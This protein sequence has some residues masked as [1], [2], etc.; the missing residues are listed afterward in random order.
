MLFIIKLMALFFIFIAPAYAQWNCKDKVKVKYIYQRKELIKHLNICRWTDNPAK[1][2]NKKC[3][4]KRGRCM[5]RVR[6][7]SKNVVQKR[8]AFGNLY[9]QKCALMTGTPVLMEYHWDKKW[10]RSSLCQF[11][12][13]DILS[14]VALP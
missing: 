7:L 12:N 11:E 2:M 13:G 3:Y 10:I 5:K 1:W 6:D 14:I 9:F 4:E 8:Q